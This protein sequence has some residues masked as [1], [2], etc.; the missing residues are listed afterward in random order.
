MNTFTAYFLLLILV[1]DFMLEVPHPREHHRH[2]RYV[3]RFY[4]RVVVHRAAGLNNSGDTR[5][6]CRQD[7][8]GEGEEGI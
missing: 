8:V 7:A 5:F 2:A 1:T 4:H 6:G 3:C